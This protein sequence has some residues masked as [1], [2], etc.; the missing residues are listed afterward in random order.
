MNQHMVDSLA[1]PFT[2]RS[3]SP[4]NVRF[5]QFVS[6]LR[7]DLSAEL[8]GRQAQYRMAP[9][10][11]DGDMWPYDQLQT[12]ARRSGVLIL[13]YPLDGTIGLPLILRPTSRGVHSGQ[14]SLPGGGYEEN[15][16]TIIQT[17]LRETYE[18][19]GVHSDDVIVLGTLS[20]LYIFASNNLVQPV[21]GWCE[22][23]PDFRINPN[24]V[25]QLIEITLGDLTTPTNCR[26]EYWHLR[27]RQV[28]VPF[29]AV[30]QQQ[31]WGATAMMLSELLALPTL[32][33]AKPRTF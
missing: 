9:V 13:L 25:A 30:A 15:D 28:D 8:P 1:N 14:I 11:R 26:R 29:F 27:E 12:D 7:A 6:S 18:E 5:S 23:R 2:D 24:E 17:A 10:P 3:Y 19:I 16:L 20:P 33:A 31:I 22:K 21:I 32:Q 4:G